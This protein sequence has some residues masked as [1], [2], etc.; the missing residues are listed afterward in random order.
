MGDGDAH[1]FEQAFCGHELRGFEGDGGRQ[2]DFAGAGQGI[3][4]RVEAHIEI[5]QFAG[6]HQTQMAARQFDAGF[7]GQRAIPAQ[8]FGEAALQQLRVTYGADP[9]GQ[10]AGKRQIRLI[11]RQ[12]QRQRAEGLGHGRAV[13]NAQHRHAETS[14]Q[15]RAGRRTVDMSSW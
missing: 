2:R 8:A 7:P 14:G 4:R 11:A 13:D 3:G 1:A 15:V 5:V 10:Y 9:V 12:A 6:L